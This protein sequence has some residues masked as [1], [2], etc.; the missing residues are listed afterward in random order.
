MMHAQKGSCKAEDKNLY[1]NKEVTV[2]FSGGLCCIDYTASLI[3][4][5]KNWKILQTRNWLVSTKIVPSFPRTA[6]PPP[7]PPQKKNKKNK[8]KQVYVILLWRE[9]PQPNFIQ[10][11]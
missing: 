8:K 9:Q 11:F 2:I 1:R 6:P 3:H 4:S 5:D 10:S 7:P